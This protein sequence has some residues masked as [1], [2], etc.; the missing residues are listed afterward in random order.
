MLESKIDSSQDVKSC[1]SLQRVNC[2]G[3]MK[4][5][6]NSAPRMNNSVTSRDLMSILIPF[7]IKTLAFTLW[8][9]DLSETL[10]HLA[11]EGLPKAPEEI[12]S[13]ML[14]GKYCNC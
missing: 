3:M 14:L 2:I 10:L 5:V 12:Q 6:T 7:P 13:G 11:T 4:M 1:K 9:D 8:Q